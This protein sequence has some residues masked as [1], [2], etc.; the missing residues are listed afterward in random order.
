[1]T[2]QKTSGQLIDAAKAGKTLIKVRDAVEWTRPNPNLMEVKV[3]FGGWYAYG[4]FSV[5]FTQKEIIQS[6]VE[7][8]EEWRIKPEPDA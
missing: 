7:H 6:I 4:W 2:T 3:E 1:M 8:P 5:Y